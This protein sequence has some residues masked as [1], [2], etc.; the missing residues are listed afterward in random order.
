MTNQHIANTIKETALVLEATLEEALFEDLR[1]NSKR[2]GIDEA[3]EFKR[4]LIES[5][6]KVRVVLLD[7][8]LEAKDLQ[9]FVKEVQI[10]MIAFYKTEDSF[11][12][13]ILNKGKRGVTKALIVNGQSTEE[14][15]FEGLEDKLINDEKGQVMLLGAFSY[16]S[17]VSE[18][19]GDEEGQKLSPVKRLFRLLSEERKDI[20]Y[21]FV[22]AAFV[23]IVSLT[24]PLGIQATVELVSGGVVFSSIY[25]LI[26]LV[27]LG[28]LAS[29]G[30]QV[31]QITLMEYLQ[32][33]IFTKAAMEFTFRIPRMK[34]ESLNKLHA[35]ELVN[36]FFDVL[37]IQKG[38][39]KLLGDLMSGLIQILFGLLL[40]SFY[41]AF[42]VFFGLVLVLTLVII[43]RLT[44]PRGLQSSINE[45]KY[46][47][48]VVY[49]LEEIARTLNSFKISG[50]TSLPIKKTEYNVNSY[51]I[52][53]RTH[54]KVL[55]N[56]Y[57]Y[58]V[59]FK[60]VIT[61]G[62]LI[63][64][65]RLVINGEITLGQFVASE[66]III[67]I[68]NSVEKIIT[69][70]DVV[71]DM[72]TAVDKI[73]QVTDLPL[74]KIGGIDLSEEDMDKGFSV[75]I[76][77]LSYTYPGTNT[78]A[79]HNITTGFACGE[80]VC[81]SGGNESGKTTLTN[82][83]AGINQKYEGGL[84]INEYSL[85]DLDLTNLRD[86]MAKNVST[87]DIFEG[88]ILENIVVGKPQISTRDAVD[89]IA[90]VGLADKINML[91]D[92]LNTNI[93]SGGKGFSSSFVSK[94]ILAR[95][96]VKKPRLMILNDFFGTFQRSEKEKLVQLV[97]EEA[98]C[99]LV[100]V[101]NDPMVMAAC[102]RII[103]MEEGTVAR[104]G[105]YQELLSAGYLNKIV[106]V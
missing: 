21:V 6:N 2:Y 10:P 26:G 44:G 90:K 39:P 31:M 100:A 86:K 80:K 98:L 54:F 77:N 79:I 4:D 46:K 5:A 70:M 28:I 42:F 63:I 25:L 60:A 97:T 30:L 106:K 74:E 88:T 101:S 11:L 57:I 92:G 55:V 61:G 45:S 13:V 1:I 91:P 53:R 99:T 68:L 95:C 14:V 65:T 85:R 96:L 34:V 73:S 104:E 49:W 72:L 33:R 83:V 89:A 102:D 76:R 84:T 40:L 47:Y 20:F 67:L 24:L 16:K 23:G 22:Y 59:L 56:Q 36:R 43:F 62:L 93:L 7:Q 103:L 37:T 69:Y 35:P 15:A 17:L 18:H 81:I 50:N 94:L 71:Y 41:H 19:E 9:A 52:N 58:I 29:G 78:P 82:T 66:V 3:F 27:L 87:E 51:L 38:L 32:R 12:P 64:G 8:T 75:K 105:T 48:K